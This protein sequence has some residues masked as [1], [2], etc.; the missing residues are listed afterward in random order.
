MIA[1]EWML[2]DALG[3][4]RGADQVATSVYRVCVR[5][6]VF[7]CHIGIHRYEHQ[8]PQ[9]VRL[10]AEL[11]V[12][13]PV[14]DDDFASVVNYET[15][16]DGVRAL[17]RDRHINLVETLAHEALDLCMADARTIA[18]EVRVEKLDVY[19]DAESVGVAMRR[20]RPSVAEDG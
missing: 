3:L 5:D 13:T 6:L 12:R 2:A 14:G 16:V 10:N 17:V 7:T 18:A 19:P 8:T 15:I 9:R 1:T 11:L 20:R 4:Q